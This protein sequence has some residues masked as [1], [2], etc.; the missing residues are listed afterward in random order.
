MG[1]VGKGGARERERKKEREGWKKEGRKEEGRKKKKG[2]KEGKRFFIRGQYSQYIV[3]F[4]ITK[5][6]F[7]TSQ[8]KK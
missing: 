3:Y 4:K 5:S 7:Q 6:K 8:H 1:W 2:R